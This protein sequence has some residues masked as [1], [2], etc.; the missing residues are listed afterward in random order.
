MRYYFQYF[1][2][3][4][5]MKNINNYYLLISPFRFSRCVS[6]RCKQVQGVRSLYA[7][8]YAISASTTRL[9]SETYLYECSVRLCRFCSGMTLRL[10]S[11]CQRKS[12]T[13]GQADTALCK[14][15]CGTTKKP[16][17]LYESANSHPS[18]KSSVKM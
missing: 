15:K 2:H 12:S 10:R 16:A 8:A 13:A 7:C 3:L 11:T 18:Q 14:C 9:N 6:R 4:L 5:F 17:K 1:T